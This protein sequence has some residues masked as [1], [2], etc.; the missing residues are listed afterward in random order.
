MNFIKITFRTFSIYQIENQIK[1]MILN[2]INYLE[3]NL[4]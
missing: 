2:H 4:I 1:I 3:L